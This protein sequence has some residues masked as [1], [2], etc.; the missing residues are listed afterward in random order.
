MP[1]RDD[2][3]LLS[4]IIENELPAQLNFLEQVDTEAKD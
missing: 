4:D 3:L 1:K 2:D